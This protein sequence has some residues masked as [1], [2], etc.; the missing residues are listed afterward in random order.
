MIG[1]TWIDN[2]LHEDCTHVDEDKSPGR[3][4]TI[5]D[6][7][8]I[9]GVSPSTVS[10]ALTRPGRLSPKTE[11]R[12]RDAATRLNYHANPM[13]RAL[14]TGKT[15]MI[16]LIVSDVTN[17]V[18]FDLVHGVESA[19]RRDGYTLL[20]TNTDE[21]MSVESVSARQLSRVAD[22]LLLVSSRLNDTDIAQIAQ[23]KPTVLVNRELDGVRSVVVDAEYG[24]GE[25]IRYIAG[26][27]HTSLLYLPGPERSWMSEHRW[28]CIQQK[29]A[30]ARI[31][32]RRGPSHAPTI[33]GGREAAAYVR[34]Q[35][36]SVVF[37]YNDLM[38]IGLM[39]ELAVAGISTPQDMSLIGF[40]DIFGSDF[41]TPALTT[42]ASPLFD[43]GQLAFQ[44][45]RA[46]L[47]GQ[48]GIETAPPLSTRLIV[49]G[50]TGPR[51]A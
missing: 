23:S 49:R 12:V 21:S 22:G 25:A 48:P 17:P 37:A 51:H 50:S 46:M 5:Y 32:A 10:R 3:T 35:G 33:D 19:A 44:R 29:A 43:A 15:S 27:G 39:Q 31:Q 13:A 34:E 8:R 1:D 45:I 30:W 11:E 6:I 18:F 2:R 16:G 24:I 42:I 26:L 4:V 36:P 40:D 41:T 47:D 7:A 28:E 14:P 38:A 9:A 20:L